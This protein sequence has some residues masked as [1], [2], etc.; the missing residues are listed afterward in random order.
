MRIQNT[1]VGAK[2][3]PHGG[4][5]HKNGA[6]ERS[7]AEELPEVHLLMHQRNEKQKISDRL[8]W[9]SQKKAVGQSDHPKII[10]DGTENGRHPLSEN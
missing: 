5:T 4:N 1:V 10:L 3:A 7:H 9:E 6:R 2:S 8:S